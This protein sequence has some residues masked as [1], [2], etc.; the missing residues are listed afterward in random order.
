MRIIS[1]KMLRE[2][3]KQHAD[4]DDALDNWYKAANKAKWA[5]LIKVQKMYPTAEAVGNFTIFNFKGNTY[6][7]IVDIIYSDETIFVKY[8]L[9]HAEYDKDKW[10]DDPY[11]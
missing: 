5:N 1:R 11:F 8:I 6:R 10:K 9:T 2:F 4:S 7:L 3:G